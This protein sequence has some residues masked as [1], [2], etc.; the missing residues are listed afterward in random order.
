MMLNPKD[1]ILYSVGLL[2]QNLFLALLL[3]VMGFKKLTIALKVI[4]K[5]ALEGLEC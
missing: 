1:C 4:R 2:V 5:N 3:K